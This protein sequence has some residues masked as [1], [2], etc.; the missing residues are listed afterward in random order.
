M[1]TKK[2]MVS[3]THAITLKC[4]HALIKSA[5]SKATEVPSCLLRIMIHTN[6]HTRFAIYR[7]LIA[8]FEMLLPSELL[9]NPPLD[10]ADPLR[11]PKA[12]QSTIQKKLH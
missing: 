5:A 3:Y 12:C 7:S 2:E 4:Q 6:T 9:P 11:Y 1:T 10:A 8:D